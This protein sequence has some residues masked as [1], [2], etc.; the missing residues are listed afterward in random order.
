MKPGTELKSTGKD[1]PLGASH[2]AFE[3]AQR[4]LPGGTTRI[5]IQRD[6]VPIYMASGDGAWLTDIDGNRYLDLQNNFTALIHGHAFP[7]VI[8]AVERQLR[9]GACFAN[10]TESEIVLA[11]LLRQR[12]PAIE[13][14]RFVN[15]GTEAVMFAVKAA[16]AITGR[17]KIAK[18]E[19]AYHGAYDWVEVGEHSTPD[20]WSGPEPTSVPK[21]KGT[22][23]SVLDDVVVVPFN[24]I[25]TTAAL[26]DRHAGE[27][28]CLLID[29][30]PSRAGLIPLEPG[31]VEAIREI[32]RRHGILLISDEVL[33]FRQGYH[34]AAARFGLEPDL[35]A[36][37]KII[38]GGL[39]IGA[40]AG[41]SDLMA[42]FDNS[43]GAA[44]LPQGGTFSANPLSMVAGAASMTALG[45]AAF[46]HLESLGTK[47]R[48]GVAEAA[49]ARGLPMR[50][51]GMGSLFRIH[52]KK[53]LP[54]TYRAAWP[55]A[56]ETK[57]MAGISRS[58][59][60]RG[61]LMPGQSLSALSTPMTET[62]IDFFLAAFADSLDKDDDLRLW[63]EQATKE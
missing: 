38:G 45:H 20:D 29:L 43:G 2:T 58:M 48:A 13:K 25:E 16:R 57:I 31:Y 41:P 26:L 52:L 33:N 37:G 30:A 47:V 54:R 27:L 50:V 1:R 36:L 4:V 11:E 42:I 5:T 28:A 18:F 53:E 39:P 9:L 3:R 35:V 17:A 23:A 32:T 21:A 44:P 62:D 6:P 8:E 14:V 12:V 51:I 49:A 46:E 60:A 40:V 55:T 34:G 56:Q 63:A 59:R 24:D 19:G 15:T 61:V 22:P 10:P 7:P